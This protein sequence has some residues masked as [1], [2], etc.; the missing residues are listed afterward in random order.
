MEKIN[1]IRNT[2]IWVFVI[3]VIILN[4]CLFISVNYSLFENTIFSVA[5]I[6]RS[7]FTIPYIDGGVSISRTARTFP[8]YLLF[9][10]GMIITSILLIKYW[11]TNNKLIQTINNDDTK[12]KRFLTFGV[13]SAV[14]VGNFK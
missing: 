8:T 12:N 7:S 2:S 11:I 4:L 9:K 3:P 14:F 1:Q 5:E 6:G 13:L 10:P